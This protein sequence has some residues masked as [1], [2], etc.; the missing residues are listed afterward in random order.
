MAIC[1]MYYIDNH[2]IEVVNTLLGKEKVLINGKIVSKKSATI[3][4]FHTFKIG[5]NEYQIGQRDKT[6]K[7]SG[8]I[9][10]VRKNGMPIS[11]VNIRPQSSTQLLILVIIMGLAF[12]FA[13]GVLLYN[14]YW[15][16]MGV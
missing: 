8:S 7:K 12:G 1:A 2:K 15:P 10:E 13:L 3:G 16:A 11:L 14:I 4:T 6:Y 9:F 5:N